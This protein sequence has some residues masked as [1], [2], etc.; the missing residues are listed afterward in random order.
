MFIQGLAGMLFI[1]ETSPPPFYQP[2]LSAEQRTQLDK[3][4]IGKRS[5]AYY[6]KRFAQFDEQGYLSPKWNWAAFIATFGWLLYRKRYLDCIVYTVAGWSF[7]QLNVVIVLVAFEYMFMPLVAHGYQMGVRAFIALAIW[8]FWSVMVARWADAYYYRMARREIADVLEDYPRAPEQQ[9]AHLKKEGGVSVVGLAAS[10]GLFLFLITVIQQQFLPLYAKP[11][12]T[13]IIQE[14]FGLTRVATAQVE[15]AYQAQGQCPVGM[16]VDSTAQNIRF[17]VVAQ[18]PALGNKPSSCV[19]MASLT[20]VPFPNRNLNGQRF[21]MYRPS[22]DK[23]GKWQCISTLNDKQRPAI[24]Q[25][26]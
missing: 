6:L 13:G 1:E 5:Q 7:I 9:K 17:E 20:G 11:K 3:W 23:Q 22:A 14:S 12:A 8:I 21:I 16:S 25:S 19:L 24:C 18:T 10:F 2:K 4:F 15:A 26:S